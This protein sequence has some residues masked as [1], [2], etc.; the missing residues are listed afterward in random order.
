[1]GGEEGNEGSSWR[2][3]GGRREGTNSKKKRLTSREPVLF[4]IWDK[5]AIKTELFPLEI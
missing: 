3:G 4:V 2:E 1:M 5:R